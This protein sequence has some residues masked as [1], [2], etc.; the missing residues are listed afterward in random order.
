[1][2][3]TN[4][5]IKVIGGMLLGLIAGATLG[6]LFAPDKGSRT[7][8]KLVRGAKDIAEEIGEKMK[9]EA[10][11]M[12][13]KAADLEMRAEEKIE[14]FKNMVKQKVTATDHQTVK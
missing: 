13:E 5:S 3:T 8:N 14:E 9:E 7:R 10:Q 1:M 12:R 4:S 11:S 2:E 6:V